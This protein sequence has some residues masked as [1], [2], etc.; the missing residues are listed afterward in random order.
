MNFFKSRLLGHGLR[1]AAVF[2]LVSNV[3]AQIHQIDEVFVTA[4]RTGQ[5]VETIASEVDTL[6]KTELQTMGNSNLS[7]AL[8]TLPGFQT[9]AYGQHSVYLRGTDSRMTSLYIEGIRI[10][11]HDGVGNRL[12]GGVPWEMV[13]LDMV[14]RVEVV[15]GPSSSI[16]GSDAMGGVV[17][18]F[19]KTGATDDKPQFS[20][21]FGTY[22]FRQ[23]TGQ[24]SGRQQAF[25]YSIQLST[26]ASNGYD[27]RPDMTHT[28]D[29]EDSAKHFGMAKLGYDLNAENRV[30]WV[31]FKTI[32]AYQS[33][34][35]NPGD[36]DITNHNHITGTKV[37]WQSAWGANNLSRLRYTQSEVAADSND[38]NN[39]NDMAWNYK[40]TTSTVSMDHELS[41]SI[42][43][44]N[45]LLERK[46]D[47]FKADENNWYGSLSNTAVD[48]DRSQ[49]ALGLG[50]SLKHAQHLVNASVRADNY[51]SFGTHSSYS[52]SYG[53]ELLPEWTLIAIQATGFRAPTLEELYGYYGR[54]TLAPE[55]NVSKELALQFQEGKTFGRLSLFENLISNWLTTSSTS[56]NCPA[57][58][59]CYYNVDT[60]KIQGISLSGKTQVNYVN[61]QSSLDWLNPTYNSGTNAGNQL[62]LRSKLAMRVAA[63][64][65][66][67]ATR[68]GVELQYVGKRF[69]DAANTIELPAY[70]LVNLWSKTGLNSEWSW[71]NRIDNLFNKSYQQ[72]GC[73]TSPSNC[74][75]AMPGVTF[76]TSIQWQPK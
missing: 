74:Y 70:T 12:G 64:K 20:Q 59:F 8:G 50:Y 65:Q 68:G 19:T 32:Q 48:A 5:S 56:T 76:F 71:V 29:K 60:V 63:D 62:N 4:N 34:P 66:F 23:T 33:A 22:G 43:K 40:T 51:S 42:G 31:V 58:I 30:E 53:Y 9:T 54:T 35:S 39:G 21:S 26:N 10:E 45:G 11:S 1:Y 15:R 14:D 13:P 28:P 57:T 55:A 49:N 27:T 7:H 44:W 69:D 25:D 72:Y 18:L 75:Y 47:R 38:P 52:F 41:T 46:Q 2:F 37:E 6:N 67:D 3:N 61:L 36:S 24:V 16:Y 73:S 17:Q